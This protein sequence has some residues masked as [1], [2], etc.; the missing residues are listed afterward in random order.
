MN[1]KRLVSRIAVVCALASF[2]ALSPAAAA[3]R[4]ASAVP[5][6]AVRATSGSHVGIGPYVAALAV[7]FA[8][9]EAVKRHHGE[10]GQGRP[11][12]RG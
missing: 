9:Y 5:A 1:S 8:M 11:V 2:A 4:P 3:T 6:P 7:A 10:S 12:S